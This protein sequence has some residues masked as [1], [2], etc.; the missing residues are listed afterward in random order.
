MDTNLLMVQRFGR[1]VA[2]NGLM[3]GYCVIIGSDNNKRLLFPPNG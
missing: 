2:A 1:K 3:S